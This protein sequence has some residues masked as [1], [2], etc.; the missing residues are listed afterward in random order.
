M[1]NFQ[2]H[3]KNRY[4]EHFLWNYPQV[5]AP[6]LYSWLVNIGWRQATS[7][8]LSQCWFRYMP[9][10]GVTRPQ[11]VNSLASGRCD[12]DFKSVITECMGGTLLWNCSEVNA[13]EHL[14]DMIIDI[15]SGNCV[16]TWAS[17]DPDLCHHITSLGHNELI[18]SDIFSILKCLQEQCTKLQ[19]WTVLAN[20]MAICFP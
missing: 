4:L 1:G 15:S 13:T 17:I 8:Y 20:I 19:K 11:F 2:T 9:P 7:H 5:N 6:R 14:D 18:S 3:I 12:N 10:S 16:I